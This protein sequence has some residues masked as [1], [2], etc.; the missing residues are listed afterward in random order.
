MRTPK[1]FGAVIRTR[2]RELGLTQAELAER[3]GVGRPWIVELENGK[4]RAQFALVLRVLTSLGLQLAIEADD[5]PPTG[6]HKS[7]GRA[8]DQLDRIIAEATRP[9]PSGSLG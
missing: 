8:Y 4:P 9:T 1:E 3:C 6:R 7:V 2:R 5:D